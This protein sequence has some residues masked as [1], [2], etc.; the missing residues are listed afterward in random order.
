MPVAVVAACDMIRSTVL[1]DIMP[2]PGLFG[3]AGNCVI[4]SKPKGF[5]EY[6]RLSVYCARCV[7]GTSRLRLPFPI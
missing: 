4:V 6:H 3:S 7:N 2:P 1:V 5:K